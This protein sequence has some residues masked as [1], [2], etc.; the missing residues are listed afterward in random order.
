VDAQVK[1]RGQGLVEYALIFGLIGVDAVAVLFL[2]GRSVGNV[3]SGVT[4]QLVA[5]AAGAVGNLSNTL[6]K[7]SFDS[8]G[9]WKEVQ[10]KWE[11]I[12]GQYRNVGGGE[13]RS[14]AFTE[15]TSW[16]DYAV[17]VNA[18]LTKGDGYGVYFRATNPEAVNAY[19]FQYDPGYNKAQGGEFL[20]RKV[21]D[22]K[23]MSPIAR[24][25]APQGYDWYGQERLIKVEARGTTLVAS[26][27]GVPV[28]QVEDS[29][30]TNGAVGLRTWDD[31]EAIFND[32][33]V[34]PL[35]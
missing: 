7:D 30:F 12:N 31:T 27:D 13:H 5:Q 22:G 8:S 19:V 17:E 9:N 15:D 20:F 33:Q 3:F 6:F 25:R 29:S 28:L 26:I 32:V 1:Q 10:G 2:L 21:V 24:V 4:G 18:L 34:T 16:T 14:F 11:I 23:E 35:N